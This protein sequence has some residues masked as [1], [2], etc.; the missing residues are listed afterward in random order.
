MKKFL[1]AACSVLLLLFLLDTAYYRWGFYINFRGEE[2]PVSF[3]AVREKEILVDRGNGLLP[4][5]IR[6][7][8]MGAGIPGHYATEFA[9]DKDTYLRWFGMIHDMGANTIRIYTILSDDFYDAFYEY[10]KDNPDPL[11]LLHGVWVNDYVLNSHVDAYDA[12]FADTLKRDVKKVVD[13]IHGRK[14]NNLGSG[15]TDATGS[16]TRDIS[17]WVLGYILGVEWED[18]TVAYTDHMQTDRNQYHG[19]YMYTSE[20]AT[21]FEAMLASVGDEMI[22]YETDKYGEQR[23]L[24]FSN[25]PTTD[26]LDYPERVNRLFQK[27]AKVDVEHIK[28]TERFISGQF[29]SYHVYPYYPDYLNRYEEWKQEVGDAGRR[30]QHL[31]RVFIPFKP[32]P[33]HAC[34]YLGVRRTHIPWN[35]SEGLQYRPVPGTYDGTA[36]GGGS[37]FLL[38]RYHGGGLCRQR[39]FHLAGRVV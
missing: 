13:I 25:W 1:T 11:Y 22:R 4:Y 29:A 27:C 23:L 30:H 8:D 9:I 28:T 35:G 7:V 21:P 39:D 18:V 19:D 24:A 31:R 33:H 12:S 5:E 38:P 32:P 14:K 10:N 37:G 20:E 16:Y 3:T 6:G 15:A 36:A 34:D 2:E 17:P 26:P